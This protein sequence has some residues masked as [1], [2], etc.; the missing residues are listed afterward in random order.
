MHNILFRLAHFFSLATLFLLLCFFVGVTLIYCMK[1]D[2]GMQK[3]IQ[4]IGFQILGWL[5]S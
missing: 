1:V 3:V 5:P 4:L 2:E